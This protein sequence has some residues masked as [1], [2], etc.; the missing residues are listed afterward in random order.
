MQMGSKGQQHR[1]ADIPTN[2]N[3]NVRPQENFQCQEEIKPEQV[4][5]YKYL[6][7]RTKN[8]AESFMLFPSI[9][10]PKKMVIPTHNHTT[11]IR[12]RQDYYTLKLRRNT[13]PGFIVCLIP[14]CVQQ[15][16]LV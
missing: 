15:S 10:L 8:S 12:S 3:W 11:I 4:H 7:V 5:I 1:T 14:K 13:L 2:K 6:Y 16:T 9:Q